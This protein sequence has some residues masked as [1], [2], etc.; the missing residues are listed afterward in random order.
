MLKIAVCDDDEFIVETMKTLLERYFKRIKIECGINYYNDGKKLLESEIVYDFLFLDIEMGELNGIDVSKKLRLKNSA[1]FVFFIT[2]H[3]TFLD[4]A[5][6]TRPF[7]YLRKPIDEK[8]LYSGID[9]ALK[10]MY[11]EKPS[12]VVTSKKECIKIS[13]SDIVYITISNRK[14][15]V[16][17]KKDEILTDEK[18]QLVKDKLPKNLFVASH[19]SFVVNL[20]YVFKFNTNNITLRCG[21]KEYVVDIS[22]RNYKGFYN[23]F[24]EYVRNKN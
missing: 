24:F 9:S 20:E 1:S 14:A 5:L 6:D 7:R 2:S 12:I 3:E 15:L 23:K 21:D 19:N 11:A 16:I 10:L 17:T 4:D 8:R 18:Y 13:A 22:R